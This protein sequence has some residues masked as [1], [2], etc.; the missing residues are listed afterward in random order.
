MCGC[1]FKWV[2]VSLN[3]S[4]HSPT[5]HEFNLIFWLQK[6]DTVLL[7]LIVVIL[8]NFLKPSRLNSMISS[9]KSN[10][11]KQENWFENKVEEKKLIVF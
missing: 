11:F 4:F 10:D 2:S 7:H 1:V 3:G 8:H 9:D 6:D 5:R